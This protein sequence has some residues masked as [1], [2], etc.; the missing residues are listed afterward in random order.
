MSHVRCTIQEGHNLVINEMTTN[1]SQLTIRLRVPKPLPT[2]TSEDTA[3]I[4]LL[5]ARIRWL[6]KDVVRY[7]RST[8][9][10]RTDVEMT[11]SEI[12]SGNHN[13]YIQSMLAE[14]KEY[15]VAFQSIDTGGAAHPPSIMW[16]E[17]S[18]PQL[19]CVPFDPETGEILISRNSVRALLEQASPK[20]LES[21]DKAFPEPQVEEDLDLH[22]SVI[23]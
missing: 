12:Q 7:G 18:M 4:E 17:A 6:G 15:G 14:L 22:L 11:I 5:I 3:Y 21:F 1:T 19:Q 8:H 13:R 20:A 23:A 10:G 2:T 16:W 9:R